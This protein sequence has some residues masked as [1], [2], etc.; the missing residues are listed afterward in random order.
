MCGCL[1]RFLGQLLKL[2]VCS[3]EK[4][5][6]QMQRHVKDLVGHELNS[7]IYPILFDQIKVYVDKFIDVSGQVLVMLT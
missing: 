3:H 1:Y 7:A 4:F 5:G 2:L 6:Q